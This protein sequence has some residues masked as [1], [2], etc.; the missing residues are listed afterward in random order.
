MEDGL[1]ITVLMY[2]IRYVQAFSSQ[3]RELHYMNIHTEKKH[4]AK[5]DGAKKAGD[6][7]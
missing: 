1:S 3:F 6:A 7:N 5:A 4:K 2:L